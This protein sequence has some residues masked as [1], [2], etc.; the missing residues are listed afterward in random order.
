METFWA[1][2]FLAF[3]AL[4]VYVAIDLLG[5]LGAGIENLERRPHRGDSD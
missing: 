2:G 1:L 3:T 4:A 5:V